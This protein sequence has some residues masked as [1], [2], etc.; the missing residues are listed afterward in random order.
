MFEVRTRF[1]EEFLL[2]NGRIAVAVE[3]YLRGI[4]EEIAEMQGGRLTGKMRI[5]QDRHRS[6][7]RVAVWEA[8]WDTESA[9]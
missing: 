2:S 1:R 9:H 8:R 5:E 3:E 6:N 7:Y 4:A